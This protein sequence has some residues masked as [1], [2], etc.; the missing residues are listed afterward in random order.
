[1]PKASVLAVYGGTPIGGQIREI[2][3]GMQII[4][5]APGRLID[6]IERKSH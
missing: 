5:A 6:L 1:M 3:R 2:K 4:V